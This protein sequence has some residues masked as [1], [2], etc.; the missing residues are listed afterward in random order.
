MS[1]ISDIYTTIGELSSK[2][3]EFLAGG[4]N[5]TAIMASIFFAPTCCQSA[6]F[7]RPLLAFYCPLFF[8]KK[9]N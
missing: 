4:R 1:D 5:S 2:C 3:D 8:T 9:F 6:T 7:V